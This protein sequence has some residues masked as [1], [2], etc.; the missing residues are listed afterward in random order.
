MSEFRC[1]GQKFLW[2]SRGVSTS[3]M[4]VDSVRRKAKCYL[5]IYGRVRGKVT[6]ERR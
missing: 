4:V 2:M 6:N 5:I 1:L 3:S